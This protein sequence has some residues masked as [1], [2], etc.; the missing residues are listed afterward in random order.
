VPLD[1]ETYVAHVVLRPVR[2]AWLTHAQ[3]VP[4]VKQHAEPVLAQSGSLT[5][6]P[7]QLAIAS[8]VHMEPLL[9]QR[10]LCVQQR[11]PEL[12]IDEV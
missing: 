9:P 10:S 8:Q 4:D 3:V 5:E 12:D 7:G 6:P 11:A 1:E 2:K